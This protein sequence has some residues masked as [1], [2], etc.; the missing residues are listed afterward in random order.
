MVFP[1]EPTGNIGD[2]ATLLTWNATDKADDFEMNHNNVIYNWQRNRN[3]FV[4]YPLLADFVFGSR[5]G[6]TWYSSLSNDDFGST[7]KVSV[8]PNPAKDV[9]SI[10]GLKEIATVEIYSIS[11]MKMFEGEYTPDAQL[12]LNLSSGIYM[13]KV[14]EANKAIVKKLIVR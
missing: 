4:D 2:L 3:P 13:V 7:W 12:N 10:S 5:V 11:G 6:E 9:I 14:T 1:G 8:Y